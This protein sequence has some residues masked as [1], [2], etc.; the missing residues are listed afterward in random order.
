MEEVRRSDIIVVIVGHR[1]R[2]LVPKRNI[3]FSLAE[4]REGAHAKETMFG[5]QAS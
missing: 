1:Y 5:V 2:S 4:C 3:F